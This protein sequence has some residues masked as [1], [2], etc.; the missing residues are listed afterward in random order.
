MQIVATGLVK[1]FGDRRV[2]DDVDFV[3][4][5]GTVVGLLG[6]NGA[7]KSTTLNILCGLLRPDEGRAVLGG[8]DVVRNPR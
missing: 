6:P 2:L 8:H 7:G 3:A 5:A 1:T 4:R